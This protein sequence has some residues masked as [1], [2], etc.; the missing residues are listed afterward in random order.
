MADLTCRCIMGLPRSTN[1]F[2]LWH[3]QQTLATLGLRLAINQGAFWGQCMQDD[4]EHAVREGFTFILAIDSDSLFT[5]EHV[6]RMCQLMATNRHWDAL[7]ALQPKRGNR[8]PL[9]WHPTKSHEDASKPFQCQTAHFGLTLIRCESLKDIPLPWFWSTPNENNQWSDGKLN[10]DTYFWMKWNQYG[11]SCWVDPL[12]SIG[13][14]EEVVGVLTPSEGGIQHQYLTVN[15]WLN[16]AYSAEA[17]HRSLSC[18]EDR[19]AG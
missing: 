2:T 1:A 11:K 19:K 13:H 10:D 15:E 5:E 17:D 16:H 14:S 8:T 18:A 3:A 4:F 7:S 12:T 6:K 9:A